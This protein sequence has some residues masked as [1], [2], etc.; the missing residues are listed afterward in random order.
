MNDSPETVV[1]N[2]YLP[3]RDAVVDIAVADGR[4][5]AIRP[6]IATT[7]ETELDAEGALV[8]PGLIDAHVHLDMAL[9]ATGDR[10]P[11]NNEEW[12]GRID[13]IERTAAYFADTEKAEIAANVRE[14]ANRAIANGVLHLRAHTY[15]DS[16]VGTSVVE[17]VAEVL[18]AFD[19]RLDAEIVAFPQRGIRRD[20][21]SADALDAALDAGAD[22]VGG[23]DPATLNDDREGVIGTWFDIAKE[24][25]AD[26]DVHIHERGETGM[27][28]LERLAGEAVDR[29]YE[30]RVTASHAYA[31]ADAATASE[32]G[33]ANPDDS[34]DDPLDAAMETFDAAD[35][36]FVTCYG[37]T[38][39]GMPVREFHDGGLVMAHG[40]DQVRDLWRP[41]GNVNALEA[42]GVESIKLDGYSTNSG[43]GHLWRL[44]T[45][46][47]ATV[48]GREDSYGIEPGT[49]A[50]LVVH[51]T[52]SPQWAI[53]ER[54]DP[55]YVLKE[56]RVVATDGT[57][58]DAPAN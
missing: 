9:S 20:E 43:L 25:D 5:E 52:P 7:G 6:G 15:V 13:A 46:E 58:T 39:R 40:T 18:E 53:L 22:L 31:L 47:G 4:I 27:G 10:L 1:R 28:T 23:L 33:D 2:A 17:T 36:R 14:V 57:I 3:E 26:V 41:R 49:P 51:R 32:D 45:T 11:R 48:L 12:T 38:R 54:A 42:I 21:G 35:L 30:D 19:D 37:S 24:H 56:G 34:G 50:D 44:I 55:R 29:G 8:S 16:V